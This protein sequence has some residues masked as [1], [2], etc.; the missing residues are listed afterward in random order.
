[1]YSFKITSRTISFTVTLL[2]L[3]KDFNAKHFSKFFQFTRCTFPKPPFLHYKFLLLV[4]GQ[5]GTILIG[6]APHN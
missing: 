3:K 6:T 2:R 4:S 1:M 5:R